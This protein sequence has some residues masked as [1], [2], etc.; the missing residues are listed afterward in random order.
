MIPKQN[1]RF[2][3]ILKHGTFFEKLDAFE[4]NF[5]SLKEKFSGHVNIIVINYHV[6]LVSNNEPGMVLQINGKDYVMRP[7][8]F[9]KGNSEIRSGGRYWTG[10]KE[11]IFSF[12]MNNGGKPVYVIFGQC[13]GECVI[14]R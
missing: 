14:L 9:W 2:Y 4:D 10:V 13:F 5:R 6:V 8:E 7:W 3:D 11:Q 12:A 1:E